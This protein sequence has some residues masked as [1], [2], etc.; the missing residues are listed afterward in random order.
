MTEYFGP[1]SPW[2]VPVG[3]HAQLDPHSA[4][5]AQM[6]AD[7]GFGFQLNQSNWTI[8]VEHAT[9]NTPHYNVTSADGWHYDGVPL[10]PAW[11]GTSD[12]DNALAIVDPTNNKVWTFFRPGNVAE[13]HHF[14][15]G[16]GGAVFDL[17]GS[18]WWDPSAG[19]GGPWAGR[20]S[21]ASY[22]AGLITPEELQAGHIDHALA[23]A[24]DEGLLGNTSALPAK[25]TDGT[26]PGGIPNGTHLQLD[27]NLDLNSLHLGREGMIVAEA[28]QEYGAFVVER[29]GG[30]AL[31]FESNQNMPT[32]PYASMNF[33]GLDHRLQEHWQVLAPTAPTLYDSV[34]NHPEIYL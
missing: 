7:S 12:S 1:N 15:S 11:G 23:V 33:S 6:L 9:A 5:Y 19:G 17:N 20:S 22:L 2:N 16:S 3:N 26:V 13:T 4:E 8:R 21:N 24:V 29:G 10:E 14:D 28:L 27:P 34:V 31:Y 25:T 18:G 30:F 32:D